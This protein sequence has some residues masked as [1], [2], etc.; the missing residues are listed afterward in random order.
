MK[1]SGLK[2]IVV[3]FIV[4]I[5]INS[6]ANL[7]SINN[8]SST[9]SSG[10]T[11]FDDIHYSFTQH[12]ENRCESE[13]IRKFE[14]K[15][16]LDCNCDIYKKADSVTVLIYHSIKG[17]FDGLAALSEKDLTNYNFDTL[18]TNLTTGTF[19]DIEIDQRQVE[20]YTG[21]SNILL[22]AVT[23]LY[24]KNKIKKYVE[25]AN[26]PIQILLSKFQFILQKNLEGELDFKKEKLYDFYRGLMMDNS[27][28]NYE[29]EKTVSDYYHQLTDINNQE[30]Q[31]DLYANSL[32]GIA[33]G[34]QEIYDN[35]NK[36]KV[37]ELRDS[38]LIYQS[39][40]ANFI[41]QFNKLKK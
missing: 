23:G 5:V 2:R 9:S 28:N 16:A 20:A 15:R 34:H 3:F 33:K 21:I 17:Y 1:N 22:N 12:C 4:S 38:L 35:R 10:L 27:L 19:G 7:H 6:C 30:Q 32:T 39:N 36:M 18:E 24:R 11:K 25:E 31:I 29:K 37:K 13:S 26:Q 41:S 8:F 40:I 14:I